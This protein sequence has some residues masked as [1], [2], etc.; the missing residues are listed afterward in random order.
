MS[1]QKGNLRQ[2]HFT[3]ILFC[4]LLAGFT[5]ATLLKPS[6]EFSETENRVLT[7]MP[8]LTL[9]AIR[10]GEFEKDYEEYMN[11]Q[12]IL[13]NDWIALKTSVERLLLK[14]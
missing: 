6:S 3:V 8:E 2:S 12:F 14:T 13:R 4:M 7:Q 9:N 11:D 5:A 1:L 10:N